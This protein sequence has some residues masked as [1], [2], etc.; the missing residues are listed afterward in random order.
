MRNIFF[1]LIDFYTF[2]KRHFSSFA[3]KNKKF[4]LAQ[5]ICEKIIIELSYNNDN[6]E[7]QY[8]CDNLLKI[9]SKYN[10]DINVNRSMEYN[11]RNEIINRKSINKNIFKNNVDSD[12]THIIEDVNSDDNIHSVSIVNSNDG[13]GHNNNDDCCLCRIM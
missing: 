13:N 10:I 2:F 7:V 6:Y 12:K 8:Y 9:V 5:L 4:N 11:L 3:D 1:L